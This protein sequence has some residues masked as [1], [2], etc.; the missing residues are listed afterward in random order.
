M[1]LVFISR[2]ISARRAMAATCHCPSRQ[3]PFP[4]VYP[5]PTPGIALIGGIVGV[6]QH[7]LLPGSAGKAKPKTTKEKQNRRTKHTGLLRPYS[8]VPSGVGSTSI[9]TS[10]STSS[11][12]SCWVAGVSF[13]GV[14]EALAPFSRRG[15]G[16]LPPPG[17]L[18]PPSWRRRH[19]P[20]PH[21]GPCSWH[22]G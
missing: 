3:Q 17:E 14:S 8:S 9:S 18:G 22:T 5:F 16:R 15:R 11:P 7:L 21:E 10:V 12:A 6:S 1:N 19:R 2:Y 20:A 13:S 4:P